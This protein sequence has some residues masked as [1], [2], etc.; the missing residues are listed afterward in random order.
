MADGRT[1]NT[2]RSLPH[3]AAAD[4][5]GAR[6]RPQRVHYWLSSQIQSPPVQTPLARVPVHIVQ[7]PRVWQVRSH[8]GGAPTIGA[9]VEDVPP[10]FVHLRALHRITQVLA[11]VEMGSSTPS[12]SVLPLS[13]EGQVKRQVRF[14]AEYANE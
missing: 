4:T 7:A 6:S 12:A 5:I 1:A 8:R 14:A 2:G 13:F 11:A 10:N 3:P 9:T